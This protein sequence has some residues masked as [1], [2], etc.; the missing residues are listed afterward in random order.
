MLKIDFSNAFN[1]ISRSAV[2]DAVRDFSPGL[3]SWVEFCYADKP[4]LFADKEVLTSETGVQQ[5]D[6]L[7]PLLF[8]LA[9]HPVVP[10]IKERVP[11]LKLH[12]WFLDDGTFIGTVSE[13][14]LVLEILK[15]HSGFTSESCQMRAFWT[16]PVDWS[17]FPSEISCCYRRRGSPRGTIR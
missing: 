17:S 11:G 16:V 6:P 12:C 1:L 9:L 15:V 5:G 2:F 3:A 14:H 4:L 13:L 7:G 8:A 10:L